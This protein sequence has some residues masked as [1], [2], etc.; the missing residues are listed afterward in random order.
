MMGILKLGFDSCLPSPLGQA[1]S[2]SC[3]SMGIVKQ[4]FDYWI[5][6]LVL[7]N[8]TILYNIIILI[9]YS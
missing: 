4:G 1:R 9:Y 8:I 5:F 3:L 2:G 6:F 7:P